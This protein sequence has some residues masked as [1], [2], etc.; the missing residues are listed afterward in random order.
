MEGWKREA[1]AL[2][3]LGQKKG[4]MWRTNFMWGRFQ[5]LD[6]EV[7]RYQIL[8]RYLTAFWKPCVSSELPDR[9]SECCYL[10]Y[11]TR[12]DGRRCDSPFLHCGSAPSL[13]LPSPAAPSRTC[14]LGGRFGTL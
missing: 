6:L 3:K 7:L 13:L 2:L 9:L 14:A 10:W 5:F 1:D 11:Q 8:S 12:T 4:R